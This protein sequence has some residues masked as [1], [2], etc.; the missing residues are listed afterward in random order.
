MVLW[1]VAA[2]MAVGEPADAPCAVCAD[3]D[4]IVDVMRETVR[5][6]D[7]AKNAQLIPAL[8]ADLGAR[9]TPHETRALV[10]CQ[11]HMPATGED[12]RLV[13]RMPDEAP[14]QEPY[15]VTVRIEFPAPR[16]EP[17]SAFTQGVFAAW[18]PRDLQS[19]RHE[20]WQPGPVPRTLLLATV[21]GQWAAGCRDRVETIELYLVSSSA[22][23]P[24][25]RIY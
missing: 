9:C 14:G 19:C 7:S 17:V 4:R 16:N 22:A 20:V 24:A 10:L 8:S 3:V 25:P 15:R 6:H 13:V 1:A 2:P 18:R 21:Q 23:G 12:W 5:R 11:A